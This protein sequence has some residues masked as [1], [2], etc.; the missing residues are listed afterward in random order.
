[1]GRKKHLVIGDSHSKPGVS[2]ERYT[3]LGRMIA[4]QRPDIIIDI[5]DFYD[6]E[7]LC[8]WDKGKSMFHGRAYKKDIEHGLDAQDRIEEEI[9]KVKGYKPR[10][11]RCLGNH[12]NRIL[13][14]L[15]DQPELEGT[16]TTNHFKSREYGWEEHKYLEPVNI[17]GIAYCHSFASG[18]MGRPISG[19]NPASSLLNKKKMSCVIGHNHVLDF[20]TR[21][22]AM[23]KRMSAVSSGC[24][25]EHGEGYAGPQ[26][27]RMWD[28]GIV[29]LNDVDSGSFDFEWW[30]MRRIK[31]KYK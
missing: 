26:V 3:W 6:M 7:S 15:E 20:A 24:Y 21:N 5:G 28:K 16:L 14:A 25:F 8:S 18:I 12:E 1:M 23:G 17:N 11:V 2:N 10:K 4:D 22:N 31:S 19:E 27:N 13:R 9:K 30:S 29:I